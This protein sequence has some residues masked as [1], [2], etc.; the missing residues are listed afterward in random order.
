MEVETL[1]SLKAAFEKWRDQKQHLRE[2]VPVDLLERARDAA[3]HHGPAEVARATKVDQRRLNI[4]PA[5]RRRGRSAAAAPAA[6]FSRVELPMPAN[7]APAFAEVVTA[8]G[9]R[10]RLFT[11]TAEA[12]ELLSSLCASGSAR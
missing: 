10:L 3:R 6:T 4:E 9:L 8:T 11:P 7:A 2:A 5:R 1:A 12:M